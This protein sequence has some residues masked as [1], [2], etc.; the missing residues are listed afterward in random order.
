MR[1]PAI[2]ISPE[3][4][5]TA[6]P[7]ALLEALASEALPGREAL[8]AC[9]GGPLGSRADSAVTCKPLS[10]LAVRIGDAEP[11]RGIVRPNRV[12]QPAS[13]EIPETVTVKKGMV[14]EN[15]T[16]VPIRVPSP[17]APSP[18]A[19]SPEEQSDIYAGKP[20]E[21]QIDARV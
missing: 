15:I 21:A 16:G 12:A 11:V 19:P 9:A 13:T 14:D 18:A 3:N 2:V 7:G 17:A 4:A 5:V 20:T 1:H 6:R 8:G 10:H